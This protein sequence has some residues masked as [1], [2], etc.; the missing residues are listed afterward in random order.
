MN[1]IMQESND[2]PTKRLPKVVCVKVS[3][4]RPEY[5]NLREWM[6]DPD[7]VYIGRKGVVFINKMRFP[8]VDSIW[9][10]PYKITK[11]TTREEAIDKYRKRILEKITLGI[12]SHER[13]EEL[14]GKNLGCW[15]KDKGE[16][17]PCHG[18]VLVEILNSK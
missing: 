6:Q 15:C 14:R 1:E 12:I 3:C 18:D 17:T 9:A 5:D 7:N 2:F 8:T 10:N 4:I 11:D 16:N 13:L